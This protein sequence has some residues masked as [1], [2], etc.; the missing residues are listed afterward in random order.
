MD[1]GEWSNLSANIIIKNHYER[2]RCIMT[3]ILKPLLSSDSN[4]PSQCE[5]F[6]LS[7][8]DEDNTV[9]NEYGHSENRT[10]SSRTPHHSHSSGKSSFMT[11]FFNLANNV[12]GVGLLTLSAAKAHSETGWIPSIV[13]CCSLA[14]ASA[15]TFVLI[16]KA[17]EL[18]GEQTF[19]GL[20]SRAFSPSSAYLVDFIVFL[21]C[22]MGLTIYI[23][24]LGDIFSTLLQNA[25]FLPKFLVSRGVVIVLATSG[26]LFPLS[27]IRNLSALAF[28]SILGFCSVMYTIFFMLIRATDG[29]YQVPNG[30]FITDDNEKMIA[31]PSFDNSSFMKLDHHALILI[32][33]LGLAFIAHYNAPTYYR[34]MESVT[35]GSFQKMV[36]SAYSVLALIYV[37]AMSAGYATF[38]DSAVGNVLLNYHHDDNLG[39]IYFSG[40]SQFCFVCQTK[41][42]TFYHV[43]LKHFL[44]EW[45]LV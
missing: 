44:V 7:G 3:S 27:L 21:Q 42:L 31:Q 1:D 9:D 40:I 36:D 30:R 24:L 16:G 39:E 14:Y 22:F 20:W 11:S 32:S 8:H 5:Y 34:E 4:S 28:T 26:A 43:F 17:C 23:G 35:I 18:T 25:G 12:A 29:T 6:E 13:I 41:C 15:R 38:G 10:F 33:N 45:Q 19:K 2:C 37:I